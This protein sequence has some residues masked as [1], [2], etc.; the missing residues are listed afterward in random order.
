MNHVTRFMSL[1]HHARRLPRRARSPGPRRRSECRPQPAQARDV[2]VATPAALMTGAENAVRATRPCPTSPADRL[3]RTEHPIEPFEVGAGL[4]HR[5]RASS[6]DDRSSASSGRVSARNDATS[7]RS[8][9]HRVEHPDEHDDQRGEP[10]RAQHRGE[11]TTS[12]P[13]VMTSSSVVIRA[14]SGVAISCSCPCSTRSVPAAVGRARQEGT[15]GPPNHRS[16]S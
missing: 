9:S 12:S 2:P 1:A 11:T 14:A 13:A 3:R 8:A 16:W 5:L 10:D 6:V 15:A 4:V 7:P